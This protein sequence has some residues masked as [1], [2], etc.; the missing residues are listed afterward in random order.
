MDIDRH[1]RFDDL[2]NFRD[3]GGYTTADGHRI[4]RARVYRADSLGK[5]TRG[6]DDWTRFLSLGIRTVIDLRY[7]WEI[8]SRGRVPDDPSFTYHNLSIEHRPYDQAALTPDIAPGP[9]LAERY[10]EVAQDGTKE[11]RRALELI[12]Q[13][14]RA[15]EPL[16]FHCAS[17]KDRTGLIAAL[18]LELLEVPRPAIV[19][20]F[21][22]T[23]LAAPALLADWTSH[24]DG[25]SPTW[26]SY[27][28][29]PAEVMHLFLTDL[30]THYGSTA[31]YVTNALDLDAS[32]LS[33]TLREGLLE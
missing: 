32:A 27:G 10:M 9:Y 8:D 33:A 1:I 6:T 5:L 24:N 17:G 20:D 26:P 16:A 31:G 25:R 13:A 30:T 2:H 22:L 28:R 21:A 18:V 3:L 29:A 7:P 23:D 14:A 4:R 19:E 12:T 11:I 15:D